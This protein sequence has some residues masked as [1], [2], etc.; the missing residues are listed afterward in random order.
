VLM[1]EIPNLAEEGAPVIFFTADDGGD[2][3]T[4]IA[5]YDGSAWS[6]RLLAPDG[7]RITWPIARWNGDE[8]LIVAY[9]HEAGPPGPDPKG[10]VSVIKTDNRWS[11]T[12]S[13]YITA[14]MGRPLTHLAM[15]YYAPDDQLGIIHAYVDQGAGPQLDASMVTPDAGYYLSDLVLGDTIA[16]VDV[17]VDSAGSWMAVYSSGTVDTSEDLDLSFIVKVGHSSGSNWSFS[18]GD[19]TDYNEPLSLALG[20]APDDTPQLLMV[21]GRNFELSI[22]PFIDI[23]ATLYYDVVMGTW[24]GN[25]WEYNPLFES[26]LEINILQSTADVD[27]GADISWAG[28]GAFSMSHVDGTIEVDLSGGFEITGGTLTNHSEYWMKLG[29]GFGITDIFTGDAGALF[30]W[31]E[32]PSGSFSCAYIKAE[33]VDIEEILGGNLESAGELL[34]W[35]PDS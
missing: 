6:Q 32:N 33:S 22:P 4:F 16:G 8:G 9:D 25:T 1:P 31:E 26:T 19:I 30:D 35:S 27:L 34:Y 23:T 14:P 29:G 11:I 3:N 18:N 28:N 15:D 24:L 21:S 10:M 12:S 17:A 5:Y 2:Q 13:E 7:P 20:Y